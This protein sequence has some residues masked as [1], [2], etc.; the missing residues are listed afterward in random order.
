MARTTKESFM[1]K[2]RGFTL[3]ELM[4]TVV[5]VAILASVAW[6]SY[7]NYLKRSRRAE[8]QSLMLAI[9]NKEQQYLLDAR[10]YTDVLGAGGL[11]IAQQGWD[12]T[13]NT[14]KT[15]ANAF[16]DITVTLNAGPPPSFTVAGTPKVASNQ[17]GDGTLTFV[18]TGGKTRMVSG[19]DK[20]W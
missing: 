3:I 7:Q 2:A 13:L 6:P 14:S 10:Q 8:A 20:G 5:I 15:C 1:R 16:Y 4:I 11:A 17:N 19:V 18:S 12:C 9:V